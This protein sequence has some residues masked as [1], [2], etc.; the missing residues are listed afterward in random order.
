MKTLK[1]LS[2]KTFRFVPGCLVLLV[3]IGASTG[4]CKKKNIDHYVITRFHIL[5]PPPD[6]LEIF[7]IFKNMMISPAQLS[8]AKDEIDMYYRNYSFRPIVPPPPPDTLSVA[9]ENHNS[10]SDITVVYKVSGVVSGP[11]KVLITDKNN[12][13]VD[14]IPIIEKRSMGNYLQF[15][16]EI[17]GEVVSKYHTINVSFKYSEKGHPSEDL[18]C[19]NSEK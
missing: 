15:K 11:E 16:T 5:P 12:K 7:S 17:S 2:G 18:F 6:T 14:S 3:L 9:F 1:L 19:I 10:L 13:L 8:K 4:C